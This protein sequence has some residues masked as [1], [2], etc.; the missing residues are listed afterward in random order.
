MAFF[1]WRGLAALSQAEMPRKTHFLRL[2]SSDKTRVKYL[3]PKHAGTNW[4]VGEYS[5]IENVS[6]WG[7]GEYSPIE[8]M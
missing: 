1:C 7:V 3:Q 2:S 4:G 8:N 5:P 6:N